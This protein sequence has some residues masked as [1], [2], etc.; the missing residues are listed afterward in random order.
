MAPMPHGGG[1]SGNGLF[2]S[3]QPLDHE[4]SL[5]QVPVVPLPPSGPVIGP[6]VSPSSCNDSSTWHQHQHALS[7]QPQLHHGAFAAAI[8]SSR[9]HRY[10][11]MES[12]SPCSSAAGVMGAVQLGL[13]SLAG[14]QSLPQD[15]VGCGS[16]GDQPPQPLAAV[17][18]YGTPLGNGPV[19]YSMPQQQQ[20]TSQN[21]G[22]VEVY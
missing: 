9:L 7:Q 1:A 16:E 6:S 18:P 3:G 13:H 5:G 4:P 8:A 15:L 11:P 21:N 20:V 17:G 19:Q 12:Q 14:Y 10:P 22:R 2:L